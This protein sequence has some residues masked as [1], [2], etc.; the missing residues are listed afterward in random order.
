MR[1]YTS[2]A[3]FTLFFAT[4]S[5][6][7][8]G[9]G[10]NGDKSASTGG[11]TA[12]STPVTTAIGGASAAQTNPS[13]GVSNGNVGGSSN[14][15]ANGGSSATA[16]GSTTSATTGGSSSN[17]AKVDCTDTAT[18]QSTLKGQYSGTTIEV[19][20]KEKVY[21]A[22][23]NWWHK[24]TVQ[25]VAID[26]L[27]FTVGNSDNLSVPATD[28]APMGYPTLYVGSY[29]G[30]TGKG[31][32]LPKLVS[33]LTSVPTIFD[34]NAL[35]F[36]NSNY[37]AAYDVWFTATQDPLPETQYNPGKGG[38]YLM[39][40]LYDPSGRQP[41]GKNQHPAHTVEGVPGT[42]D[43][44]IDPS[45]PP[46]ISYLS[47]EPLNGLAFDL[48]AFIQDNVKNGYG[49]KSSMYLSVVFAGF[50]IWGGGDGLQLKQFCADV[51]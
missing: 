2:I 32:N 5:T 13:T 47:T 38:A 42:W 1:T 27:G 40:W 10:D 30:S 16:T 43:V 4:L 44:W 20:D 26:G 46:C 31:S 8:S 11:Q 18:N 35:D 34:T 39:V 7:C 48:N 9:D 25:T 41:R 12:S 33:D 24:F 49:V 3:A 51:K 50:E 17:L 45:D 14:G 21:E 15:N 22:A 19:T 37:N 23:T 28:G 36:D 29:A 6:G